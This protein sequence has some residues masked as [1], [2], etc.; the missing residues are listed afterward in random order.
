MTDA[1]RPSPARLPLG[2][3]HPSPFSLQ[4]TYIDMYWMERVV[5]DVY[6]DKFI[7]IISHIT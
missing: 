4:V 3:T 7:P 5:M 1:I 2:N 6:T